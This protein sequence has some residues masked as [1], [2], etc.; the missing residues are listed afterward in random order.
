VLSVAGTDSGLPTVRTA[1]EPPAGSVSAS[2]A[3]TPSASVPRAD[4]LEIQFLITVAIGRGGP[5]PDRAGRT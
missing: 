1:A 3:T 2:A 5:N 4:F